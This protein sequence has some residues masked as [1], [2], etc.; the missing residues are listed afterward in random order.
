MFTRCLFCHT[1]FKPGGPVERFPFHGR[2]A[3][4]PGRGRLWAI[5]ASCRR[6]NLA[7]IE[8]RWEALDELEKLSRDRGRLLSETDNIALIRVEE[9]ELVRVGRAGLTEEA[10]WRYGKELSAR[11]SRYK[12]LRTIEIVAMV[13]AGFYWGGEALN[14]I[15]RWYDFGSTAWRGDIPCPKCGQSLTEISFKDSRRLIV[16]PGEDA[17]VA[18]EMGC[19]RCKFGERPGQ[20]RLD[21]L[22]AQHLLRRVLAWRH[23]SGASENRIRDATGIIEAAGSAEQLSR[24]LAEG[25]L[26]I[27]KLDT[28]RFRTRSIA[29]EIALNDEVERRL[30]EAELA[31]LEARWREEEQ[32]AAIV[33]GELTP[34]PAFERLRRSLR[35]GG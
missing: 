2:I 4:D 7:P 31:E 35:S 3:F 28:K 11:R 12:R 30:L 21:G 34:L 5:C 20:H 26:T 19:P 9:I 32:L 18:I 17:G 13:A 25:A 33:D 1:A 24:A 15:S 16:V 14:R 23:Y 10:W 6:W 22:P 8:E 29:L 27:E